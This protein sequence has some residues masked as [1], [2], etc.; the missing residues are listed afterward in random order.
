MKS[1]NPSNN[2]NNNTVKEANKARQVHEDLP[3]MGTRT[4]TNKDIGQEEQEN[5]GQNLKKE[6]REAKLAL[7]IRPHLDFRIRTRTR[8]MSVMVTATAKPQVKV[9]RF[10]LPAHR[11]WMTTRKQRDPKWG[12]QI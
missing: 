8:T 12:Q 5:D 11:P 10:Q 3:A 4:Q 1:T 2:N 6:Q 7:V 9:L